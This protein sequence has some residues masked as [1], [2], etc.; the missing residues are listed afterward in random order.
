[1]PSTLDNVVQ[2]LDRLESIP[3]E[4]ITLLVVPGLDWKEHQLD[5]IRQWQESGI[6]LAGHGWVHTCRGINTWYH[7]FHSLFISRNVAEHLS[8]NSD[9]VAALV[10]RCHQWFDANGLPVSELYVPPAWA[11]GKWQHNSWEKVPFSA[12]ETLQGL[13]TSDGQL[14][15]LPL[16][17]FEADTHFRALFLRTFNR[18]SLTSAAKRNLPVRISI[19]PNDF[20]L[21]LSSY[22]QELVDAPLHWVS[23]QEVTGS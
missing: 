6:Q 23:Y 2:I 20:N 17:G 3:N 18:L 12:I 8:L 10:Q 14:K 9:E 16:V 7:R 11:L 13:F 5:Q 15:K 1:M 19:H 4:K 21:Y 22:L